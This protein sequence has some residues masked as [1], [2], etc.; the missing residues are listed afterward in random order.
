MSLEDTPN[1]KEQ[2]YARTQIKKSGRNQN[3]FISS[4]INLQE[5]NIRTQ[6]DNDTWYVNQNIE[7]HKD[8]SEK[9]TFSTVIDYTFDRNNPT[10]SWS[11]SQSFL[12]RIHKDYDT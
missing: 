5:D 7:W 8:Q 11:A 10:T 4:L 3:N 2:W 6:R 9:H 12:N 1:R